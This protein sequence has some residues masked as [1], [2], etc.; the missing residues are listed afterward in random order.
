MKQH[1]VALFKISESICFLLWHRVLN[2][3]KKRQK[4]EYH[5]RRYLYCMVGGDMAP[6]R[7]HNHTH[8]A[9]RADDDSS[10]CMRG[11]ARIEG[12]ATTNCE[13]INGWDCLVN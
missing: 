11:W 12:A 4:K 10:Q 9:C 8:L 2:T 7:D 3:R 13:Y 5:N 1:K 6:R